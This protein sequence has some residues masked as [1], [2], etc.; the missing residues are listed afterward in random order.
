MERRDRR[1]FSVVCAVGGTVLV[2]LA[3]LLSR[4][5]G[6]LDVLALAALCLGIGAIAQ[7]LLVLLGLWTPGRSVEDDRDHRRSSR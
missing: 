5:S 6:F 2:A 1:T 4:G 3:L 7:A